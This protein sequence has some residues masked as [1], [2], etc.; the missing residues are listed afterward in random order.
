[1]AY[2][3]KKINPNT[4]RGICNADNEKGKYG[5]IWLI[6][7]HGAW[8]RKPTTQRQNPLHIEIT[9]YIHMSSLNHSN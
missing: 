8:T 6:I 4:H 2:I 5:A 7:M 3:M 9:I 1:V